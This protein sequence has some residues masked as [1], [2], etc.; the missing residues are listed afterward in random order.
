MK[1][2]L[3]VT[4]DVSPRH[5][6]V[7]AYWS[8]VCRSLPAGDMTVLTDVMDAH[9]EGQ[10]VVIRPLFFR[11][12]WPHWFRGVFEIWRTANQR[13]CKQIVAA[14]LLPV[15]S[16]AYLLHL[17]TSMPYSVQVYGMDLAQ[18]LCHPRKRRLAG[19]I[20]RSAHSIIANSKATAELAST[21]A[22]KEIPVTVVYPVP[23]ALHPDKT[24][25]VDLRQR[26]QLSGK[27]MVLSIGRLVERKGQD[28]LIEAMREVSAAQP[29]TVCVIVGDGPDRE[30]LRTLAGKQGDSIIFTGAVT[31]EERDAW[32]SLCDVFV[33]VS[34]SL[35]GDV[36]G[37]GMVYLEASSLGKPIVAGRSGGAVEAVADGATG[38]LVD[39]ESTGGIAQAILTLL[40]DQTLSEKLGEEGRFRFQSQWN[41]ETMMDRF[42]NSLL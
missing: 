41:W 2:A 13:A 6:G 25:I 8:R 42:K 20:L 21:C 26:Y 28:R 27:R 33:M 19:R 15:G 39:P 22:G 10:D 30:R 38:L 37:F 34:R 35:P 9:A 40:K 32:L 3:L 23:A 36:E 12:F 16:M 14:Q 17:F 18:V 1:K 24:M 29:N 11:V 4:T 5:G 7:A 31:A